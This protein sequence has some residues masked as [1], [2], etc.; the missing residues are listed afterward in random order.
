MATTISPLLPD[1]TIYDENM[2]YQMYTFWLVL[3]GFSVVIFLMII[4][5]LAGYLYA[6]RRRINRDGSA[7][8]NSN[9]S[10]EP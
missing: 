8:Y 4:K 5:L 1:K 6:T 10:P 2:P 3:T 9:G 7:I